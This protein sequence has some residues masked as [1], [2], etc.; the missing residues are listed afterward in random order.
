MNLAELRNTAFEFGEVIEVKLWKTQS[1][2]SKSG[3]LTF[4]HGTN[5]KKVLQKLD[6]RRVEGWEHRLS[7]Y[8]APKTAP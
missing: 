1:G 2:D 6:N 5:V 8:L 7:A 3:V 4:E